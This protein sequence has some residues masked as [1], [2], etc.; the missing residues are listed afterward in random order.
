MSRFPSAEDVY[1]NF[2][3]SLCQCGWKVYQMWV[4]RLKIYIRDVNMA[5]GLKE[6]M[7]LQCVHV[8]CPTYQLYEMG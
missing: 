6:S 5:L 2:R 1:D 4:T 3:H 7:G 8:Q